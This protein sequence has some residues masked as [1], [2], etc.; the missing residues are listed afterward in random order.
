MLDRLDTLDGAPATE[1]MAATVRRASVPFPPE[2]V[3]AAAVRA[4]RRALDQADHQG[5]RRNA[6]LR[7]LDAL[8]LGLD[9]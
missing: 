9:T 5:G 7:S 6:L 4:T 8:G 3:A 2:P 1:R